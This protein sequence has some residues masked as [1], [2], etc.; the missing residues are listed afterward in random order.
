[1]DVR[2][3]RVTFNSFL[4][5]ELS[6]LGLQHWYVGSQGTI[7]SDSGAFHCIGERARLPIYKFWRGGL[8]NKEELGDKAYLSNEPHTGVY[9]SSRPTT[10]RLKDVGCLNLMESLAKA[11]EDKF[12][13]QVEIVC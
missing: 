12:K 7:K 6:K 4:T 10:I 13:V 3:G 5:A 11:I 1:M 9:D 2:P 8:T